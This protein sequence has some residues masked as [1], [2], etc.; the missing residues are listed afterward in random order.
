MT[1]TNETTL[2]TLE[3]QHKSL[4]D[5]LAAGFLDDDGRRE[6][7]REMREISE[8]IAALEGTQRHEEGR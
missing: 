4:Q 8:R 5:S 2:A 7:Y 6:A 1:T 3:R